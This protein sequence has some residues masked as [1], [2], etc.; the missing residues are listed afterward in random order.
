MYAVHQWGGVKWEDAKMPWCSLIIVD[1]RIL[2]T[3]LYFIFHGRIKVFGGMLD[4]KV[5]KILEQMAHMRP[6]RKI[7]ESL[8]L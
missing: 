2:Q 7:D 8:V 4:T 3:C 5:H 1:P 6:Y